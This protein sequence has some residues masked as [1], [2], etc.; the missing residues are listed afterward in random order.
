[1]NNLGDLERL[2]RGIRRRINGG[3]PLDSYPLLSGDS[4]FF[5]CE[6]YFDTD[7]LIK[8]PRIPRR[9]Q[10]ALSIFLRVSEIDRFETY[11]RLN[12]GK[13]FDQYTLVI[14]NG[15]DAIQAKV[16]GF[17]ESRFRKI[18]AVNLFHRSDVS[19][20]IPIGL[21]NKNYFTNGVPRDFQKLISQEPKNPRRNE[22]LLLQSFS[23]HT[24]KEE[25]A[26]CAS[27]GKLLG[28]KVLEGVRPGIYR[29]ALLESKF[30]LSPAGNGAD[31]HRTW[32]A[33]YLGAIPIVRRSLWPFVDYQLPVLIIDEWADLLEINL[34]SIPEVPHL[35][36]SET[37]WKNYYLDR[38]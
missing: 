18:Y 33:M 24:N 6:Y 1:M 35:A 2:Y 31:C 8:V 34:S 22:Y 15:D 13:E 21:E 28:S 4:Y 16:L 10:K 29:R 9:T 27:V 23:L 7:K 14:H 30:V 5:S 25:R 32:E 11:L 26:A 12:T 38:Q 19:Q 17:F 20:P 3:R 36:W 37:F